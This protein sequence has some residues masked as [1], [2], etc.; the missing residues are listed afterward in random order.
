MPISRSSASA[1]SRGGILEV[2]SEFNHPV[3]IVTKSALVTRDI[4]ILAPM[5]KKGLVK[6]ALSVTTLDP[7]LAR[8]MEPRA[9]TP[10][11][12][13]GS[14]R[15][16]FGG[17]HSHRRHGGAHHPRGERQRDRGDP[18]DGLDRG[19]ARGRLCDAAPAA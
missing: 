6:V 2:L 3:G 13:L 7:K 9:A 10:V 4:D 17:G 16:A 14:D 11:K 12:R 18:Q 5:A 8:A 1:A 19:R 15:A